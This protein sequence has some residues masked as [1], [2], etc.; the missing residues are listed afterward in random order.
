MIKFISNI[1]GIVPNIIQHINDCFF[2]ECK[3]VRIAARKYFI[4]NIKTCQS[5]FRAIAM[6]KYFPTYY[7]NRW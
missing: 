3:P 6:E 2:H 4:Q 5:Q 1:L 7:K